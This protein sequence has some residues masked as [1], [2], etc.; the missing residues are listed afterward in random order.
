MKTTRNTKPSGIW[1]LTSTTDNG[2]VE[3][4]DCGPGRD[5]AHFTATRATFEKMHKSGRCVVCSVILEARKAHLRA[6]EN[7][8]AIDINAAVAVALKSAGLARVAA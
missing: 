7:A 3:V 1:H 8:S 5:A 6:T 4:L 2:A